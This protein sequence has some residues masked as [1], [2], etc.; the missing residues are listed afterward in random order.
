MMPN[1]SDPRQ[2]Q[3]DQA[4]AD[5][6][7]R[8]RSM[9]V[10]VA[11]LR[12]VVE[13][14]VG[15]PRRRTPARMVLGW[16]NP[17][18]AAAASLLVLGMIVVLVIASSGG[19]VMASADRLAQVHHDVV[20]GGGHGARA[21]ASIEEANAALSSQHP[22]GPAVP[23]VAGNEPVMACC[24]HTV[25]RKRM[26]CVSMKVDGVP[27]SMAVA[28]AADVRMPASG[29]TVVDGVTY[30]VQAARDVNMVMLQRNGRWVCLMGKIPTERLVDV[31]K[32]L[33]F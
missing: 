26:S 3:L 2:D 14:Q 33:R 11:S 17:M 16:V 25:G 23:A 5:R 20:S 31:A 4:V 18:R 15:A 22:G 21:V 12:R 13:A 28:D 19:P 6:L 29:S 9:P 27:V 24:V 8:L 30:H 10:D 1:E 7:A 32:G